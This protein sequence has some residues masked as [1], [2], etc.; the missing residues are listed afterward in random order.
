M[1]ETR[2]GQQVAQLDDEDEFVTICTA[3]QTSTRT[4][5][6]VVSDGEQYLSI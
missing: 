2:T 6:V 3:Q 4:C 1:Y 5:I